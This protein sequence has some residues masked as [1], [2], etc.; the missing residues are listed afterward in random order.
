MQF[1]NTKVSQGSVATCMRCDEIFSH[2]LIAYLLLLSEDER[3]LKI[4]QH[5]AELMAKSSI[6]FSLYWCGIMHAV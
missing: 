1:M 5:L 3:I 4:G 6:V 2:R